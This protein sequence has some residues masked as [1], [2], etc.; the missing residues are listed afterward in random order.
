MTRSKF[1]NRLLALAAA[2]AVT[3]VAIQGWQAPAV[4][5]DN[6][7]ASALLEYEQNTVD[8][9]ERYGPS[10][11]AVDVTIAGRTVSASNAMPLDQFPEFFR[12]FMPGFIP[13]GQPEY[14]EPDRETAGSGFVIDGDGHI[15]T[16][17]HVVSGAL[18]EGTVD[19]SEGS[20]ITVSFPGG[21]PLSAEVIGASSIYDL[22]LLKLSDP[23]SLPANAV[24]IELG[25]TASVRPGQKAIAIGNPFGFESTVTLGIVSAVGR[26]FPYIGEVDFPMVQTDAPINPGNSGGPLLDSSGR[27]IGV[28]TAILPSLSA[29]G[30][31]GNLGIGFA[32][33][34][35]LVAATLPQL[36]QGGI[37]SIPTRPRLGVTIMDV[38]AFPS[39]VRE[40]LGLPEQGVGVLEVEPGG[41]AEEAGIEGSSFGI[42]LPGVPDDIAV[43]GD[44]IVE[45]DGQPIESASQLQNLIITRNEGD[46]VSLGIIRHGE[47]IDLDVTLRVVPDAVPTEG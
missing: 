44:V 13:R 19:L 24:P 41:A 27:L 45:A 37:Q 3:A 28:N 36:R 34:A 39:E 20:A 17:Y 29:N 6:A 25:D 38:S 46:V 31:R 21:T 11:V 2:A 33:P 8:V 1:R 14:Q 35:D 23:A 32:V 43:P 22:A 40:R 42:R 5:Q 4:A 15:L 47:R 16:N 9:V 10:V 12:E 7:A 30:E 18:E 26:H